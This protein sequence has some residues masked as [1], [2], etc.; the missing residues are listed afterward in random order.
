MMTWVEVS[1]SALQTNFRRFRQLLPSKVAIMAVVKAN[2]YGHGLLESA[3]SFAASGADWLGVANDEE[4]IR[5]AKLG[6]KTPIL[7][8]SY[9]SLNAQ[10]TKYLVNKKV[11]FPVYR[12]EQAKYLSRIGQSIRKTVLV[13]IKIDTGLSRLGF[14]VFWILT[15]E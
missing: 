13:Q 5:L 12:L 15:K 2:A 4:A 11:R 14:V 3:R 9:F 6:F 7:I 10:S 1:K 8:L